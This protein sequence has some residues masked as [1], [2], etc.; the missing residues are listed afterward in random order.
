MDRET[1]QMEAI[2][3]WDPILLL[4]R[5][6]IEEALEQLGQNKPVLVHIMIGAA[7]FPREEMAVIEDRLVRRL[8]LLME[9]LPKVQ[10]SF[11]VVQAPYWHFFLQ[12]SKTVLAMEFEPGIYDSTRRLVIATNWLAS[13]ASFLVTR[14]NAQIY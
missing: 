8:N 3:L 2:F 5:D 12:G 7:H 13:M 4:G 14:K 10:E 1:E 11:L 6:K 9:V